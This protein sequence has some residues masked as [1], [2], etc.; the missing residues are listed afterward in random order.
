MMLPPTQ[1]TAHQRLPN[2]RPVGELASRRP[3]GD[4][5]RYMAG[6]RCD[7]CRAANAAYERMRTAE[8]KAGNG[9]PLVPADKAQAHLLALAAAGVG[10][11]SVREATDINLS[12]LQMIRRGVRTQIRRSTE[13]KIL[14]VP[15]DY[16]ANGALVDARPIW[17]LIRKTMRDGGFTQRRIGQAIHGPHAHSLQIGKKQVTVRNANRVRKACEALL[18]GGECLVSAARTKRLIASMLHDT[19]NDRRSVARE[20]GCTEAELEVTRDRVP[21]AFADAVERAH[22]AINE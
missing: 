12:I 1:Q 21:R 14:A 9:N 2:M 4:R 22:K 6:C 20:I 10:R 5:L 15:L 7:S 19:L 18:A 16:L 11:A 17:R 8:R 3:H 13:L